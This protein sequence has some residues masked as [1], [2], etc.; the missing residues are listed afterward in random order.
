[1]PTDNP[2]ATYYCGDEGYPAWTDRV[3][4]KN[5]VNMATYAKGKTQFE[6]LEKARDEELFRQIYDESTAKQ[7]ALNVTKV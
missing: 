1:M 5:V 7:E 2:V 6:K 3:R 4:W